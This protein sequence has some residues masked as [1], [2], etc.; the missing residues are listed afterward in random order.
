MQGHAFDNFTSQVS[1]CVHQAAAAYFRVALDTLSCHD[2]KTR[3]RVFRLV[4]GVCVLV[5]TVRCRPGR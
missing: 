5:A 2:F 3:A 4:A 1:Y